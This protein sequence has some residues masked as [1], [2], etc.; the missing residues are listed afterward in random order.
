MRCFYSLNLCNIS[1]NLTDQMI[2]FYNCALNL[3]REYNEQTGNAV[4]TLRLISLQSVLCDA[5]SV[6]VS[7]VL[8]I[9]C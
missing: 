1:L 3:R 4:A 8:N 6:N 5:T 7:Y 9:L 2:F